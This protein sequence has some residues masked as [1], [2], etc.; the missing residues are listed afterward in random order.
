VKKIKVALIGCGDVSVH[1]AEALRDID[2]G[3][4]VL[5][6]DTQKKVAESLGGQFDVPCTDNLDDVLSNKEIDMVIVAVPHCLH[7]PI[8]I[9]AAG[10]GKHVMCEKPLAITMED[11][12]RMISECRKAGVKLGVNFPLRYHPASIKAGELLA[13]EAIGE[14]I[15]ITMV[16]FKFKKETYWTGG[17]RGRSITHWRGDWAKSGGGVLMMNFS[18]YID[19]VRHLTG[20]EVTRVSAEYGTYGSPTGVEVEDTLNATLKFSNGA[21]GSI[22]TSTVAHGDGENRISLLGSQGQMHLMTEPMKVYTV[23]N[24]VDLVPNQWNEL[25]SSDD[26]FFFYRSMVEDFV[27]ALAEDKPAPIPGAEGLKCL[28]V[29]LSVYRAGR[30]AGVVE[31]TS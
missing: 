17:Y 19:L 22:N 14:I 20:L 26:D 5:V 11:G 4:L 27:N 7:A 25:S 21:V 28:Q 31:I 13:R 8:T 1:Y 29:V 16:L 9:Q 24:D 6:M 15:D 18:H 2:A 3:E 23:R 10:A 12:R 30:E